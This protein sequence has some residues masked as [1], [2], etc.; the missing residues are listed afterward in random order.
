[1]RLPRRI[2]ANVFCMWKNRDSQQNRCSQYKLTAQ[3]CSFSIYLKRTQQQKQQESLT[4]IIETMD[5]P[6]GKFLTG[7]RPSARIYV[8]LEN[9]WFHNQMA[10]NFDLKFRY[11]NSRTLFAAQIVV[12]LAQII[13]WLDLSFCFF[14]EMFLFLGNNFSPTVNFRKGKY[15]VL[16]V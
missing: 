5:L 6:M 13:L 16:S 11:F 3:P 4:G 1:M 12:L 2:M 15:R 10:C 14:T 8:W 9:K 7:L